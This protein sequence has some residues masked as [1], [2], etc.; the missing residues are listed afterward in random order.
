MKPVS[1]A[2]IMDRMEKLQVGERLCFQ[3]SPTF[4]SQIAIIELNPAHPKKGEKKFLLRLGKTEE[5]AR[6]DKPFDSSDKAKHLAAWVAER[7]PQWTDAQLSQ[8]KAAA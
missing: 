6:T 3:L 4:A 8:P 1:K 7:W 2:E 5:R